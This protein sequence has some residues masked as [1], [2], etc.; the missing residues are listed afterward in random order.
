MSGD[1][2]VWF[3]PTGGI[4]QIRYHDRADCYGRPERSV[5]TFESHAVR[6]G[7]QLCFRCR[8]KREARR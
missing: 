3:S 1:A 4:S 2:I 5:A 7:L 8:A 6:V